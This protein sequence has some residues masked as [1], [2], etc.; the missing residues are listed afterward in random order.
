M[1]YPEAFIFDLDGV[2]TDTAEYHFLAWQ[3]L[4]EELGISI[5]REFNEKLKGISRMESL[6]RIIA[7]DP[8]LREFS[9]SEKEMHAN[10]K[11]RHYL[12][13]IKTINS[14][15]VLP[16]IVSLLQMIKEH[17]IKIAL[18]S[19]SKNAQIVLEQ[20][21]LSDYFDYVVD[22]SKVKNGK[23]DPE[24]FTTAADFLQVPYGECVGIEDAAAGVE[25]INRANMFSVGVGSRLHLSL[26]DY[27]VED[28]SQLHFEEIVKRFIERNKQ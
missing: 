24:T 20:L 25:A 12:D 21:G 26:A 15:D 7:L 6:E 2:L 9:E 8:S 10:N 16:G 14:E 1:K 23:P 18:G 22:A 5:D 17:P 28:T 3:K 13:L 19:A 4:A 11:N 27:I